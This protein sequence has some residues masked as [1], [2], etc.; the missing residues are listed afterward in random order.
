VD[1]LHQR[2]AFGERSGEALRSIADARVEI[3]LQ[4][5]E[6]G[7]VDAR[8][9]EAGEAAVGI[10]V[11]KCWLEKVIPTSRRSTSFVSSTWRH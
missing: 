3:E 1:F 4:L 8:S 10:E 6:L 9:D 7:D 2:F 11:R 5:F